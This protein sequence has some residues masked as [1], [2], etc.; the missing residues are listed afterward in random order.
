[1]IFAGVLPT[2]ALASAPTALTILVFLSIA[3]TDGSLITMPLPRT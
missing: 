2:I 1:M 3:T